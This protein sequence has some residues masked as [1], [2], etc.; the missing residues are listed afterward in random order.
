MDKTIDEINEA[1]GGE[2]EKTIFEIV[3]GDDKNEK[4]LTLKSGSW[5]SKEP[6]FGIDSVQVLLT[7]Y[8]KPWL[9]TAP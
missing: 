5:S 4:M 2:K 3:D 7:I 1:L 9:F 8:P 6:W